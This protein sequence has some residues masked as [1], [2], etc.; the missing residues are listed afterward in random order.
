MSKELKALDKI[1]ERLFGGF[2]GQD[3]FEEIDLI[4][5]KLKQSEKLEKEFGIDLTT[6]SKALLCFYA[7]DLDCYCPNPIS[8]YK[9]CGENGEWMLCWLGHNYRIKD[10]RIT[11]ALTRESVRGKVK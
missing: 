8:L 11:W 1:E 5:T 6:L 7:K 10:Y 2:N 9:T 4:R 3:H